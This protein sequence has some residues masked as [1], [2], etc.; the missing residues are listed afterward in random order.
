MVD[1]I[2]T[3]KCTKG[4][5]NGGVGSAS[6]YKKLIQ[7]MK[8][9][10]WKWVHKFRGGAEFE[11]KVKVYKTVPVYFSITRNPVTFDE[12]GKSV[13]CCGVCAGGYQ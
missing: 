7:S 3:K 6:D 12:T 9:K 5:K 2:K 1:K 8:K 4:F 10:G 13:V 11:K